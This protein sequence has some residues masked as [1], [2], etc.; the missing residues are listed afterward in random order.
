MVAC[1]IYACNLFCP[2]RASFSCIDSS[3]KLLMI[4]QVFLFFMCDCVKYFPDRNL[5]NIC[6]IYI[7]D[8]GNW[9]WWKT[10]SGIC[11]FL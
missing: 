3:D 4:Y 2:C 5:V 11:M 6:M 8:R 10:A 1:F 7:F 9:V